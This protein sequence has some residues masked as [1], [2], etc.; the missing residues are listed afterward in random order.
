[1]NASSQL[2]RL[3]V[4][5]PLAMGALALGGAVVSGQTGTALRISPPNFE[6]AAEPGQVVAQQIRV[7][8][9]G[10]SPLPISMQIAGFRPQGLEGQVQLTEEEEAG[11]GILTW[12][13]VSP[14]EFL[15]AP[16]AEEAV[17]FLIEVPENAPPGGH[18]MSI[19]ASLGSGGTTQGVAVGQRI[20]SLV[21]LRVAGEVVEQAQLA[22][23]IAPAFAAKGPI[24]FDV[25][26][27][28]T[29]NV[30][31]RPVGEVVITG[32]F[33]GEVA[34]LP[35][36]QRNL[37]PDSERSFSATWETGWNLG[38]YTAEYTGIYGSASTNIKGSTSVILFPWPIILPALAILAFLAFMFIRARERLARSFRV[39]AGRE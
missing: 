2:K 1:M 15:L 32:T 26:L 37:L 4:L 13:S 25:V 31:L 36:E 19:L 23:F 12:T 10:D 5:L 30:H 35:L 17:T 18:Y 16:G 34:R 22:D 11:F 33:G 21:L 14:R 7:S 38:R 24:E 8:N 9:R 39:L 20:G 3:V 29:G 6:I 27:R 28:N